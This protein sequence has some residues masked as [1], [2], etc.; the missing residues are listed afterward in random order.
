MRIFAGASGRVVIDQYG[1][2]SSALQ[3]KNIQNGRYHRVFNY[4]SLEKKL[5]LLNETVL[6]WP[7]NTNKAPLGRPYCGFQ[8]ELCIKKI[9]SDSKC[10]L[11]FIFIC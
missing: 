10:L 3:F 2:R 8:G 7:G 11:T 4:F 5:Q 6:L 9:E 1:D